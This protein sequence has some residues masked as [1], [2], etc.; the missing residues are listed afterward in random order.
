MLPAPPR[1]TPD[2]RALA[3]R[4]QYLPR[5]L[6]GQIPLAAGVSAEDILQA[7]QLGVSSAALRYDPARGV[8][9]STYVW[10]TCWKAMT[11]T[12]SAS[13]SAQLAR[14]PADYDPAWPDRGGD[15]DDDGPTPEQVAERV[16]ALLGVLDVRSKLIIVARFGL[17]SGA[18]AVTLKTLGQ[19]FRL[20]R[21]RVRQIE[22]AALRL[23]RQAAG[24][25]RDSPGTP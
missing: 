4:W 2:R 22:Q 23:L 17:A 10:H 20:S 3:E 16:E 18:E 1:L 24:G 5:K 8:A 13:R 7:G 12:A 15:G 6:L 14:L 21:E 19:I 9:F 25:G 11:R